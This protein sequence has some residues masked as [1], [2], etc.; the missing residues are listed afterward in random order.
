[1]GVKFLAPVSEARKV[2]TNRYMLIFPKL[3]ERQAKKYLVQSKN[4]QAHT[5]SRPMKTIPTFVQD[6][7]LRVS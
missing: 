6:S 3:K 4:A 5:L 1:M 2:L 7:L